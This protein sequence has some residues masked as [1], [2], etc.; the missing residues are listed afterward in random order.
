M[1]TFRIDSNGPIYILGF[2]DCGGAWHV[3]VMDKKTGHYLKG[4]WK[5]FPVLGYSSVESAISDIRQKVRGSLLHWDF[6]NII[7]ENI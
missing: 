3:D 6:G 2:E 4:T 5:H 1:K 7:Y